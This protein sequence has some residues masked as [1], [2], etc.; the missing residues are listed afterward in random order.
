MK[1]FLSQNKRRIATAVYSMFTA[2]A[3]LFASYIVTNIGFS[4]SGEADLIKKCNI[5]LNNL[6]DYNR[7]VPDSI[8]FVNVGYD[9][10]LAD[11]YDEDGF[12]LG[13]IDVT[14]R[15]SLYKFLDILS[16]RN[17]YKYI[18]LD[19]FFDEG[20]CTEDDSLLFA[21]IASMERIVIPSTRDGV[22]VTDEGLQKKAA[23]SDYTTTFFSGG[24]HKF[25]LESN[26]NISI[27]YR[28]YKDVTGE[29]ITHRGIFYYS[30]GQLCNRT[31]FSRAFITPDGMYDKNGNRNYYNLGSDLLSDEESLSRDNLLKEKYIFIGD[32][33]L[34]DTH[35][36]VM[37]GMQGVVILANTFTSLMK[38]Q[39]IIPFTVKITLLIIFFLFAYQI[40]TEKSLFMRIVEWRN[41]RGLDSFPTL[42]LVF[43]YFTYSFTLST[44]CLLFY[45][46]YGVA[47]DIFITATLLQIID[48]I[49]AH[50]SQIK[51]YASV[52]GRKGIS[53]FKK[54]A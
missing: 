14:N 1:K 21:K 42:G 12:P 49:V 46:I 26:G 36:T 2:M 34:T 43:S 53:I 51:K 10:Q 7:G 39:H 33:V 9:K 31:L 29:E 38:R 4:I 45:H 18:V 19:V 50:R 20:L 3:L 40:Y 32:M 24:Y 13:N 54:Q 15:Y 22:L 44:T 11:I 17:D 47:Y 6:F 41:K 23:L 8:L 16:Q 27:P 30:S 48:Y 52:I 28:M 35:E 37:G 25:E 5:A